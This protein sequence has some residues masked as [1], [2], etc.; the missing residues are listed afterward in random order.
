M[1]ETYGH[2]LSAGKGKHN[3]RVFKIG[4]ALHIKCISLLQPWKSDC[5]IT[6]EISA[7]VH[8]WELLRKKVTVAVSHAYC[9]LCSLMILAPLFVFSSFYFFFCS[10][11]LFIIL[12]F[13]SLML[14]YAPFFVWIFPIASCWNVQN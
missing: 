7:C 12:I 2:C 8:N 14:L 6:R 1:N 10:S 9:L 3:K 13:L 4:R 11:F 5:I